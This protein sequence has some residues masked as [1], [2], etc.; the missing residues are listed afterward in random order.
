MEITVTT[1][2]VHVNNNVTTEIYA[3][4]WRQN[5]GVDIGSNFPFSP[6]EIS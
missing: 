6:L 4:N 2:L 5:L 1:S 3:E